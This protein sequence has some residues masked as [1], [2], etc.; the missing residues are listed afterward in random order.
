MCQWRRNLCAERVSAAGEVQ[1][2]HCPSALLSPPPPFHAFRCRCL[3]RPPLLLR[4]LCKAFYAASLCT[5]GPPVEKQERETQCSVSVSHSAF[6]SLLSEAAEERERVKCQNCLSD[7]CVPACLQ[8]LLL[9]LLQ[10]LRGTRGVGGCQFACRVSRSQPAYARV[11]HVKQLTAVAP[12][13]ASCSCSVTGSLLLKAAATAMPMPMQ[14]G[15]CAIFLKRFSPSYTDTH[16]SSHCLML[17]APRACSRLGLVHKDSEAANSL[18]F[19]LIRLP[20]CPP[21]LEERCALCAHRP[22]D[23]FHLLLRSPGT[24]CKVDRPTR[25]LG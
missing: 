2:E 15:I 3:S 12:P 4:I 6:L 7:G 11:Y 18:S 23:S 21:A 16:T 14:R 24:G 22:H 13:V 20:A 10:A 17:G 9:L 5:L 19:S 1:E 8:C 25:S